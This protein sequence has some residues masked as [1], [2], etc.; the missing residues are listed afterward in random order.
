MLEWANTNLREFPWRETKRTL[1]EV[2]VAEF[3]LTQT[4]ADNVDE[5]YSD[6]L[7][8]YPNL[9]TLSEAEKEE[10]EDRI[11]P[12]GF[13]RIR[14]EAL[15]EIAT[16]Y[17]RLPRNAE[18]LRELPQVGV[19]VANA[20]LCFALNR[21]LPILDRNVKRV[22][23]RV[24]DGDFPDS[25]SSRMEFASTMLPDDGKTARRYN[26]A[27]LDFGSLVCT[28]RSP[29]CSECFASDYCQYYASENRP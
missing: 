29:N 25:E 10:L 7:R 16:T 19:Y 23:S 17:D 14:S 2:F 5:I 6:F 28:K 21:S 26:L 22:Y 12:L 4:P 11:K 3:F 18:A 15:S 1:Y 20:S 8:E 27:L 24:F 9:R 13:H